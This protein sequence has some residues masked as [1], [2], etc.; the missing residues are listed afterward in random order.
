MTGFVRYGLSEL[1]ASMSIDKSEMREGRYEAVWSQ[2]AVGLAAKQDIHGCIVF[3]G[4][5]N[6]RGAFSF[7]FT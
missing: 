7:E 3:L 5:V 2:R 1:E 4:E 6:P